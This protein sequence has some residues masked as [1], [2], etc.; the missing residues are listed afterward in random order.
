MSLLMSLVRPLA[1]ISLPFFLARVAADAHPLARYYVRLGLYLSTLGICS[2]WGVISSVGMTL[3]GRRF[4]IN[5]LVARSFYGIAN[6]LIGIT[7]DVEGEEYLD[8]K[9][10]VL[11]ANHQSMLD[12]LFIGRCVGWSTCGANLRD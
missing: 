4:D 8:T 12:I 10:A 2:V 7:I 9:P 11:V 6:R 1:Y 3:I 5:W